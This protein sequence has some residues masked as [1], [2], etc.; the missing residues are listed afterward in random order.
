M[1]RSGSGRIVNVGSLANKFGGP[2]N[3]TYAAAKHAVG[4]LSDA[5]RW[6]LDPFGIQVILIEP[7]AI[8]SNFEQ[9][10]ARN[11]GAVVERP[12]SPYAPFCA[13]VAGANERIRAS[14]RP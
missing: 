4:A 3:G 5:L 2:A 1:R 12:D 10:V 13:R 14:V 6:E 11:S 8:R 9:T 7:G